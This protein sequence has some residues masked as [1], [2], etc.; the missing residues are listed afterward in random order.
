MDVVILVLFREWEC[1]MIMIMMILFSQMKLFKVSANQE[2][3][4]Y[5]S[6]FKKMTSY[7]PAINQL[8]YILACRW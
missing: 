3:E 6:V 1:M 5:Y 4:A 8:K 2:E 7:W